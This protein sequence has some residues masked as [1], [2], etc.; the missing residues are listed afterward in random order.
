MDT[1]TKTY[2]MGRKFYEDTAQCQGF[3]QSPQVVAETKT[4]ITVAMTMRDAHEL[5]D[6]AIHYAYSCREDYVA[7]GCGDLVAAA[8]RTLNAMEKQGY[9]DDAG[10]A[11]AAAYRAHMESG[12]QA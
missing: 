8:Q 12:V 9:D 4:T 7:N 5:W 10:K 3:R 2:R 1:S 11:A 6:R